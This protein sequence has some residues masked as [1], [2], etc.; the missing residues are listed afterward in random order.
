MQ[1]ATMTIILP[2]CLV[3]YLGEAAYMLQHPEGYSNPYFN[4]TPQWAFWP[5]LVIAT[6]ASMVSAQSLI[7]GKA[8]LGKPSDNIVIS[9]RHK[10]SCTRSRK[11]WLMMSS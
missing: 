6:L 8:L 3:T 2:S 5:V 1:F 10:A 9:Q 11:L 7:S 4:A